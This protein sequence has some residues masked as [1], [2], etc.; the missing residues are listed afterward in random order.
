MYT[1]TQDTS[2][3]LIRDAPMDSREARL[4]RQTKTTLD[5]FLPSLM[6]Q[7]FPQPSSPSTPHAVPATFAQPEHVA[8]VS[9]IPAQGE[10]YAFN[11]ESLVFLVARQVR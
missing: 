6:D 7:L 9:P 4:W 3:I 1:G 5:K 11:S 2:P 10:I 8:P